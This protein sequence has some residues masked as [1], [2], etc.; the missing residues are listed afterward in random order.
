[1]LKCKTG[2]YVLKEGER[3]KERNNNISNEC[4]ELILKR[5]K[6]SFGWL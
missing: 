5:G 6:G 1:M 3:N 2:D 4:R